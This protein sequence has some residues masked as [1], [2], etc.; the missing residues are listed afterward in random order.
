V[1][2]RPNQIILYLKSKEARRR[3]RKVKSI[4]RLT[5]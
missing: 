5:P 2:R 1:T 3:R 4:S